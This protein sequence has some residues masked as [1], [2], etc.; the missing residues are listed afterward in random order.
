MLGGSVFHSVGAKC[1]KDLAAND[2][3]LTMDILSKIPI[4]LDLTFS[5]FCSFT[6]IGFL[7]VFCC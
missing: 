6:D 7:Q 5:L 4:L 2:F 3:H 1:L